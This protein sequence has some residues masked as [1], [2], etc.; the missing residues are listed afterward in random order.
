MA[1]FRSKDPDGRA[2]ADDNLTAKGQSGGGYTYEYKGVTWRLATVAWSGWMLR[3]DCRRRDTPKTIPGSNSGNLGLDTHKPKSAQASLPRSLLSGSSKP[4]P[5]RGTCWTRSAGAPP[6]PSP[7]R[8]WAGSGSIS[9]KAV[10]LQPPPQGHDGR[11][12]SQPPGLRDDV[13][14]RTDIDAPVNY[15]QN[16]HVLYGQQEGMQGLPVGVTLPPL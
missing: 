12:V 15:R 8:S 14:R 11:P 5:T 7:R 10:E 1:R 13:P 3:G 6:R 4:P 2:W 9:P 16:K